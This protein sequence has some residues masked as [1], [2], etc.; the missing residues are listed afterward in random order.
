MGNSNQDRL[1][2][3]GIK[4]ATHFLSKSGE[5]FPFAV[6][7]TSSGELRHFQALSEDDRPESKEVLS[8]LIP[9]LRE[10][11][12]AGLYVAVA[13]ITNVRLVDTQMEGQTDAIRTA[14]VF[15]M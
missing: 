3:D 10:E 5:F 6:A 4:T 1:L 11:A 12:K 2:D 14:T 7:Q 15:Q 13:I 8:I 9:R